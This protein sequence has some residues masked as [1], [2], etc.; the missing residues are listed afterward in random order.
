MR[1]N[2]RRYG[3]FIVH[4]GIVLIVLGIAGST[5]YSLE[6]ETSLRPGEA[7]AIGRYRIVFQGL[8]SSEQPTHTRVEGVFRVFEAGHEVGTMAPALKYFPTSSTPIGRAVFRSTFS[9]DLYLILSGFSE[10][11]EGR[12]TLKALVRP[13]IAWIWI[14]GGVLTLGTLVAVWPFPVRQPRRV[15][16][17]EVA[18]G[19]P[20][21]PAEGVTP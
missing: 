19:P 6:R 4:L 21:A 17:A 2:Q 14:G 7:L 10:L 20:G 15:T 5:S 18:S 16:V 1:R 11:R 8:R 13:L 3:G 12:A 9:A